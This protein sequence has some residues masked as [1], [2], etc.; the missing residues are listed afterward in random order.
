MS[1]SAISIR[2]RRSISARCPSIVRGRLSSTGIYPSQPRSKSGVHVTITFR[3][4]HLF[5]RNA[6]SGTARADREKGRPSV[7]AEGAPEEEEERAR[8]E[9]YLSASG[10]GWRRWGKWKNIQTGARNNSTPLSRSRVT[11]QHQIVDHVYFWLP[12]RESRQSLLYGKAVWLCCGMALLGNTGGLRRQGVRC[13]AETM[14]DDGLF[15]AR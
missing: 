3:K 14:I 5:G 1:L 9:M 8:A 10:A 12:A 6:P 15:G 13:V 2:T 7:A 4:R 11:E